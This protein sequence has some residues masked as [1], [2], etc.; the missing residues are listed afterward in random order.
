MELTINQMRE[1][2]DFTLNLL[3]SKG[4]S[5]HHLCFGRDSKGGREWE[6][7]TVGEKRRVE[8]AL[9]GGCQSLAKP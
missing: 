8:D 4:V 9:I 3:Y 7:F 5:H 6:S 2:K 1:N